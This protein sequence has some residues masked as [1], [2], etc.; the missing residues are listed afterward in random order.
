MLCYTLVVPR[1]CCPDWGEE[2]FRHATQGP[3]FPASG[4]PH[5]GHMG[6]TTHLQEDTPPRRQKAKD[7]YLLE[8]FQDALQV[9]VSPEQVG[10][11]PFH[12][13][14]VGQGLLLLH[15]QLLEAL[16]RAHACP[17]FIFC[18]SRS[19]NTH[20]PNG[21]FTAALLS[22]KAAL[23]GWGGRRGNPA[24]KVTGFHPQ[25]WHSGGGERP[26]VV[27]KEQSRTGG[28]GA[29]HTK[30]PIRGEMQAETQRAGATGGRGCVSYHLS[31]S[32]NTERPEV[33]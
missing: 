12:R 23:W 1:A 5:L 30:L 33:T 28:W 6:L 22:C 26:Q 3:R 25:V 16:L 14:E 17:L 31:T 2:G 21:Q 15:G 32:L 4:P 11:G 8:P 13:V 29:F 7:R 24:R 9:L 20:S 10:Q 18:E 19:E 27:G